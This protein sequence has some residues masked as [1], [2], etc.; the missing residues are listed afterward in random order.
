SKLA[1][2][3][4]SLPVLKREL[5][6][7]YSKAVW[8]YTKLYAP[9][10]LTF[11]L[12]VFSMLTSHKIMR[13]RNLALASAYTALENVYSGYRERVKAKIGE[14]AEQEIFRNIYSEDVKE[15]NEKGKEV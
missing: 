3:E 10:A 2:G 11:S 9:T 8:E 14:K 1:S 6:G 7:A 12:S 5:F 4:Y 13:G 15:T